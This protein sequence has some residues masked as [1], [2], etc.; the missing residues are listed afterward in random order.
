MKINI[1]GDK[2]RN[3]EIYQME[4]LD[5]NKTKRYQNY[6]NFLKDTKPWFW[7]P[8]ALKR[9]QISGIWH[10]RYQTGNPGY[11]SPSPRLSPLSIASVNV[12][13][14]SPKYQVKTLLFCYSRYEKYYYRI[15]CVDIFKCGFF[16]T[17]LSTGS[18]SFYMHRRFSYYNAM[19]VSNNSNNSRQ[20]WWA[21]TVMLCRGWIR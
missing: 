21:S 1:Y 17:V 2:R 18:Y 12:H 13:T 5:A 9:Y 6:T 14:L 4:N 7:M 11:V 10:P 8:T 3:T 19:P 16:I 15:L 20:F